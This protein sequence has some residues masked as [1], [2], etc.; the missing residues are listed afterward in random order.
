[1]HVYRQ[2]VFAATFAL[3]L[4]GFAPAQTLDNVVMNTDPHSTEEWKVI[5]PHLPDPVTGAPEKL[6]TAADVLRARRFPQDAITF[7]RAAVI[8]GGDRGRLLKKEGVVQLEMQHGLLARLCFQQ[9]VKLSKNDAE[10]WNNM[11]AAD[12]MLGNAH[13]AISEYKHAVKLRKTSAVFH[14]NLALAYFEVKEGRS[15]RTELN[16]AVALD[17]EI[18][19]HND[20]GG[21]N[22]QVLAATHYA[23]ICFEMARVY[24]AQNDAETTIT[25]LT[26]ASERGLDVRA[27]M[28][29]DALLSPYLKMERVQ[30]MLANN[31]HIKTK[32]LSRV[33]APGLGSV[34][35]PQ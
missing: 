2:L 35:S 1:M 13:A 9:A 18:L 29:S 24:A 33:K 3:S 12:F 5:A 28:R 19:H 10:A 30:V 15:A 22:L 25:W 6:E 4:V 27:A 8:N 34:S 20:T 23:E 17:P 21:Y 32:D 11:G 26:K 31:D 16:R 14:S 7:Y